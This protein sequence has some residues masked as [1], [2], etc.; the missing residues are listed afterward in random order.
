MLSWGCATLIGISKLSKSS[1]ISAQIILSANLLFGRD[2]KV[3]HH[4]LS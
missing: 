1:P 2:T 4:P 3:Y